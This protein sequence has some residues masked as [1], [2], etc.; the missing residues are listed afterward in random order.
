MKNFNAAHLFMNLE[1]EKYQ[2][3]SKFSV[4]VRISLSKTNNGVYNIN[5]DE[6]QSIATHWIA[7]YVNFNIMYILIVLKL[8]IFQKKLEN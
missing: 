8:N 6:Y 4:Y 1:T 2:S 5:L 3:E 7:L